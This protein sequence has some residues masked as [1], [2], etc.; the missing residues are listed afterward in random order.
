VQS[1]AA[2]ELLCKPKDKGGLG[3]INLELQNDALLLKQ[4]YK[5]YNKDSIP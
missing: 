2:W 1:L 3:I 5:F 4:I